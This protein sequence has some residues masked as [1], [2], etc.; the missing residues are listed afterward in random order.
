V[1]LRSSIATYM[2]KIMPL[3]NK[4][5]INP[6]LAPN[7][8]AP[9]I[10]SQRNDP[11]G[12]MRVDHRLSG[13]DQVFLRYGQ[14]ISEQTYPNGG[15]SPIPADRSTN[16]RTVTMPNRTV[17]FSWTR[18]F[19]PSFFGETLINYARERRSN[20]TGDQTKDYAALLGTPNPFQRLGFPEI[21]NIGSFDMAT[22]EGN[23]T[24][25]DRS[26]IFNIQENM[27]KVIKNHQLEFGATVRLAWLD[28]RPQEQYVKGY[29]NFNSL[30]TALYDTSR[31]TQF[32]NVTRTGDNQ[33][34]FFLGIPAL[35]RVN[36]TRPWYHFADR[37]HYF[38]VQDNWKASSRLT[39]NLGLRI[40]SFPIVHEANNTWTSFDRNNMAIVTGIS[41]DKLYAMGATNPGIVKAYTDLGVKFTSP[42]AAGLPTETIY[43]DLANLEPRLGFAYRLFGHQRPTVLRGGFSRFAYP[44]PLGG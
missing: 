10:Q 11:T 17:A 7:Y 43:T 36:K 20:I 5:D 8:F 6:L 15:D 22:T 34:N 41:L 1:S 38:Y 13:R 35:V 3:P 9:Y 44:V 28:I 33:A 25:V 23:Q 4:P 39:L 26:R 14:G 42:Q 21:T 29:L 31:P 32:T 37:E 40:E 12:T 24:F 27:T 16:I 18:L 2:Y 19:G 30:A